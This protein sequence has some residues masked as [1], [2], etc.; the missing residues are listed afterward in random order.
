MR[1][2]RTEDLAQK[3]SRKGHPSTDELI[4]AQSV[5]FPRDP[6]DLLGSFWPDD[7]S[8]DK[9]VATMRDG[10]VRGFV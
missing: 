5:T 8:V 7:E 2:D 9:F 1:I 4:A 10:G 6:R 3:Y